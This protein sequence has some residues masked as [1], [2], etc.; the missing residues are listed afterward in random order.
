[1]KAARTSAPERLR[2]PDRYAKK[3]WEHALSAAERVCLTCPLH[4]C[5]PNSKRCPRYAE[6]LEK[7]RSPAERQRDATRRAQAREAAG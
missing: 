3:L 7:R 6:D 1:M 2:N 4:D 5:I